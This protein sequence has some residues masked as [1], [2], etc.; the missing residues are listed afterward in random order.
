VEPPVI[1]IA[2][3]PSEEDVGADRL[4]KNETRYTLV[5][6]DPDAPRAA[7][8]TSSQFRHWVERASLLKVKIN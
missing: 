3:V 1:A 7:N 8:P 6:F 4:V 2:A 5:M